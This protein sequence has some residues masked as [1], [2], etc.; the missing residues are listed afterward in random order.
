MGE[1]TVE[2]VVYDFPRIHHPSH[3]PI[4]HDTPAEDPR[5]VL[6]IWKKWASVPDLPDVSQPGITTA[7]PTRPPH[8]RPTRSQS[9]T[10]S[11]RLFNPAHYP[12]HHKHPLTASTPNH[13]HS[14][15]HSMISN[16][17]P[18]TSLLISP[19]PIPPTS[20]AY[21]L[22]SNN[23]SSSTSKTLPAS[24]V[25]RSL[26]TSTTHNCIDGLSSDPPYMC[27]YIHSHVYTYAITSVFE[28]LCI[29]TILFST[30]KI[31]LK[32]FQLSTRFRCLTNRQ[33]GDERIF[34]K[35]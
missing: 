26:R 9:P 28:R 4:Q 13:H 19:T 15:P 33:T 11:R 23:S 5:K 18:P 35:E 34:V 22:I 25:G 14:P 17:Q 20:T 21:L 12:T 16:T 32:L 24:G 30:Q 8:R 3:E 7:L 27:I 29:R 31:E 6:R 10:F 1:E 2:Y